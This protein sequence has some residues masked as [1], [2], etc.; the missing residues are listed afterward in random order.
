MPLSDIK[1][2]SLKVGEKPYK[3]S[4]FERLF[5]LVK[6]SG[7][8]SWRFKYCTNGQ[9]KLL[10]IRALQNTMETERHFNPE[11]SDTCVHS[12]NSSENINLAASIDFG[13]C[14]RRSEYRFGRVQ[15]QFI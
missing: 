6:T 4:D 11:R 12:V 2:G 3:V 13:I 10:V 9:E 1:I 5:I 7:S 15:L 8:K 14:K